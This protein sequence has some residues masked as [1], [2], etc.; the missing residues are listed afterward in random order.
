MF[1]TFPIPFC[2]KLG[3][4][5]KSITHEAGAVLWSLELISSNPLS[6]VHRIVIISVGVRYPCPRRLV[7]D[8]SGT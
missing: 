1:D 4:K 6:T 2:R 3:M 5:Y 8:S 7:G